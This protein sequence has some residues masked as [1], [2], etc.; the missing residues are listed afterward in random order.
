MQPS[1]RPKPLWGGVYATSVPGSCVVALGAPTWALAGYRLG[2]GLSLSRHSPHP[3][4][5]DC[6]MF[7]PVVRMQA[8]GGGGG[9]GT[10]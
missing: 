9:G 6:S 4:A 2:A 8:P 5:G 10:P 7:W 1:P 3:T